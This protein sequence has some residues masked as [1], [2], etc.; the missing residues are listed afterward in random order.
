MG[1]FRDC[2][3]AGSVIL[4]ASENIFPV[5]VH[6]AGSFELDARSSQHMLLNSN[7]VRVMRFRARRRFDFDQPKTRQATTLQNVRSNEHAT[8]LKGRFENCWHLYISNQ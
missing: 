4:P 7:I 8:V 2:K 5:Q 3:Q 1:D 6:Q